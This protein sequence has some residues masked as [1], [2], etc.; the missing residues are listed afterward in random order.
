M[1]RLWHACRRDRGP[2]GAAAATRLA[3]RATA[4]AR[5]RCVIRGLLERMLL[6]EPAVLKLGLGIRVAVELLGIP[7]A[8]ASGADPLTF[9]ARFVQR[10]ISFG[11]S[12]RIV[13][14]HVFLLPNDD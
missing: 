8:T 10:G 6:R 11:V 1:V 3:R 4:H 12:P 5:V 13:V 14:E 2:I 9:P 7:L